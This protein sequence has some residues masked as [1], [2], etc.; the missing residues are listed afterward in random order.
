MDAKII[1]N[2]AKTIESTFTNRRFAWGSD[3]VN[4]LE[5]IMHVMFRGEGWSVFV[6]RGIGTTSLAIFGGG[7]A[8]AITGNRVVVVCRDN[9][10]ERALRKEF[11]SPIDRLTEMGAR[12]EVRGVRELRGLYGCRLIFDNVEEIPELPTGAIAMVVQASQDVTSVG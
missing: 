1:E 6:N 7:L 8:S 10:R 4:L 9:M 11:A 2:F 3:Q 12:I 5:A